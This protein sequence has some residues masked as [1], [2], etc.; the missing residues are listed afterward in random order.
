MTRVPLALLGL[1]AVLNQLWALGAIND[2]KASTILTKTDGRDEALIMAVLLLADV[3]EPARLERL[4]C[5]VG[6]EGELIV[7][8]ERAIHR[9]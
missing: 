3:A 7:S 1:I 5:S 6:T 8:A 2:F 4:R 9:R